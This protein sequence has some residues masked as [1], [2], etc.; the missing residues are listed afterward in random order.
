MLST[1]E[2]LQFTRVHADARHQERMDRIAIC[3]L[4]QPSH[5]CRIACE[6]ESGRQYLCKV[7]IV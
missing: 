4:V 7:R 6:D 5:L 2:C 1:S 3:Y